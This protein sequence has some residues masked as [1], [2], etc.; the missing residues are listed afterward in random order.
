[1][2]S[3]P[4]LL[5]SHRHPARL[6][7]DPLGPRLRV[8]SVLAYEDADYRQSLAKWRGRGNRLMNQKNKSSA[9]ERHR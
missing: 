5:A 9:I 6:T 8:A 3:L 7:P 2:A 4:Q 1:M